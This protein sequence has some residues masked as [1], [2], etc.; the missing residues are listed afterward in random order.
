MTVDLTVVDKR[1]FKP[2]NESICSLQECSSQPELLISAFVV[3]ARSCEAQS[4]GT[5]VRG[6]PMHSIVG[7]KRNAHSTVDAHFGLVTG[8]L[9][10]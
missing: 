7:G 10:I 4:A 8:A 1:F 5:V 6:K 3:G 9:C 2:A